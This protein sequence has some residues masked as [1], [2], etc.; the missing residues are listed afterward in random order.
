MK[1]IK[2]N[3]ELR[4]PGGK[5]AA[6]S[7]RRQERVPAILY[8][9]GIEES[10]HLSLSYYDISHNIKP[11]E[12]HNFIIDLS[13]EEKSYPTIIAELQQDPLTD[14]YY[15]IDFYRIS[16]D[17]PIHTTVPVLLEGSAPGVK[18]GGMIEQT[19]R[20]VAIS[21]L[22]LDM[23]DSLVVDISRLE[24]GDSVH[25][26]DLTPPEGVTLLTLETDTIVHVRKPRVMAIAEDED[27]EALEGE[28]GEGAEG[29][30]EST[31]E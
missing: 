12:A 18:E 13:V 1:R 6:R 26:S 22:P 27:E 20:D 15:H 24:I 29:D 9:Q 28:E 8:G 17:K 4:Q 2:L 16:M 10:L 31:E 25:V 5:G 23:P 11:H 19:L 21:C 30:E 14:E 7:L 3:A